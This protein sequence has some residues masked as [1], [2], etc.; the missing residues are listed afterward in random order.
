MKRVLLG[1]CLLAVVVFSSVSWG[2]DFMGAPVSTL[3][4]NQW[5]TGFN[6][7]YSSMDID[8]KGDTFGNHASSVIS[9]PKK[10]R[11]NKYAFN[12][13]YG[14]TENWDVYALFGSVR[15]RA[16]LNY[17]GDADWPGNRVSQS[18][19]EFLWGLGTKATFYEYEKWAFGGL[20][21]ATWFNDVA[22]NGST[23]V[24][25]D[26]WTHTVK[27]ELDMME[28]Q[29]ATGASY[30]LNEWVSFYGG[31]FVH[32]INGDFKQR[33]Y[34]SICGLE[35]DT[36]D[37]VKQSSWFG[38]F[39]GTQVN[40]CKNMSLSVEYQHTAFANAVGANVVWRY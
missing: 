5:S 25:D 30:Q 39:V 34:C 37:D 35:K 24:N 7:S 16:D 2:L 8:V 20:I 14:L 36:T 21:Q 18:G 32:I 12:L 9:L 29:I 13:G 23:P 22:I 17:S 28:L 10:L 1:T 33:E 38:V 40:L 6:Y 4:K 11:L 26:E 3:E 19:N 27:G 15:N 31:P